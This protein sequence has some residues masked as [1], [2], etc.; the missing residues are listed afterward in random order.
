MAYLADSSLYTSN[1]YGFSFNLTVYEP[2]TILGIASNGY[3]YLNGYGTRMFNSN[4]SQYI[5]QLSPLSSVTSLGSII[6]QISDTTG[7]TCLFYNGTVIQTVTNATTSE[8]WN[9]INSNA[10]YVANNNGVAADYTLTYISAIAS[11][12]V[13]PNPS[14]I[15]GIY[16]S[17]NG[18]DSFTLGTGTSGLVFSAIAVSSSGQYQVACI[19]GGGIYYSSN[20]GNSWNITI[21]PSLD[22]VSIT[23]NTNSYSIYALTSTGYIYENTIPLATTTINGILN[24]SNNTLFANSISGYVGIGNQK[25]IYNLDVTGNSRFTEG[26]TASTGLFTSLNVT[27]TSNPCATF[28]GNISVV[29]TTYTSDYRIKEN[30]IPLNDTFR[31]DNLI[32]VTYKNIKTEKQDIGLVAHEL[33]E[34][35]PNLV[36]GEKDGEKMQT[37]NYIGLIPILIKEIKDLK[38]EIKLINQKINY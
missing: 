20:Y 12:V 31:V 22:W 29:G 7:N 4:T 2:V 8:S 9:I 32:P 19:N 27:S 37:V 34:H 26:I 35:F 28:G 24:V 5:T 23:I 36:T 38:N 10:P 3:V 17:N 30:I 25:P 15:Y 1:N 33:Q 21:A 14:P 6:P 13:S 11:I 16:Y 18:G